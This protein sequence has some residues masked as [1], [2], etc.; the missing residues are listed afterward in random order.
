[1]TD[2]FDFRFTPLYRAVGMAFGVRPST[3]Q[4]EIRDGVFIARFGPWRVETDVTNITDCAVTGGYQLRKTIGPPHL[5]FADQGLT[6][7]TNP[8]RGLCLSFREP[9]PG[10]DPR[11]R[12][13]HAGLTVTVADPL[14]LRHAIEIP[15]GQ[16]D[17]DSA[18]GHPR[19]V[20]APKGGHV[21]TDSPEAHGV[22]LVFDVRI[23]RTTIG[24]DENQ[25]ITL[26]GLDPKH[27]VIEWWP[28]GDEFVFTP[29]TRTRQASVN[30]EIAT[31]GLH[32]GDR[33][34]LGDWTLIFQRDE[35]ADH[36]RSGRMRSGGEA[37]ESKWTKF[38]GHTTE[39]G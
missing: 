27:A 18:E 8:D 12:I 9:V 28:E 24:A 3:A 4:V 30:G 33:L 25:D 20:V 14:A 23:G 13:R 2:T 10:V 21:S 31:T 16:R 39:I 34:Q 29:V 11:H 36:I 22:E 5:S 38:G 6:F 32:H 1:M 19:L 37:G 7:A 15:P 35:A 17:T 26:E